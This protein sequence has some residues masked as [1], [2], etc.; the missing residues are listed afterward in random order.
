NIAAPDNL[1]GFFGPPTSVTLT[2]QLTCET[3][4]VLEGPGGAWMAR[5]SISKIRSA[6]G[7]ISGS[8][9]ARPYPSAA[10]IHSFR[11]PPTIMKVTP[12]SQPA[13]TSPTP[14]LKEK[15]SPPTLLSNFLPSF[16][17]PV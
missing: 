1:S 2:L 14:S 3:V 17:H 11:F 16:N 13:M 5:S 12:S 10:G 6:L 7:G 9:P 4:H 15:G 8:E